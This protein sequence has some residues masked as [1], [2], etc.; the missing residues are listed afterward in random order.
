MPIAKLV[1]ELF[2]ITYGRARGFDEIAAF[3]DPAVRMQTVAGS[4]R[5]H[6]LPHSRGAHAGIGERVK[7]AFDKRQIGEVR[8]H[9]AVDEHSFYRR[10]VIRCFCHPFVQRPLAAAVQEVK[11]FV[12]AVVPDDRDV[13]IGFFSLDAFLQH[14]AV[15]GRQTYR[16]ERTGELFAEGKQG[17]FIGNAVCVGG[18]HGFHVTIGDFFVI[19]FGF[20]VVDVVFIILN[21]L[22]GFLQKPMRF[23]IIG[24]FAGELRDFDE[25]VDIVIEGF[26]EY[27]ATVRSVNGH[28]RDSHSRR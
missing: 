10:Q 3:V 20:V 24:V 18:G 17:N 22:Y 19:A 1:V 9:P 11:R 6:E 28:F 14:D 16:I 7:A 25:R 21:R 13:V 26:L 23:R 4:G 8:G 12:H 27:A 5:L 2:E 15:G